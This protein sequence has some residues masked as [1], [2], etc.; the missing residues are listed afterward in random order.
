MCHGNPP[1]QVPACL[2]RWL[3]CRT[4]GAGQRT[5]SRMGKNVKSKDAGFIRFL[6]PSIKF[7]YK[8]KAGG[9]DCDSR[10]R[11]VIWCTR[12]P[13]RSFISLR[14]RRFPA[15]LILP[16]RTLPP[17]RQVATGAAIELLRNAVV[18]SWAHTPIVLFS[19]HRLALFFTLC[20]STKQA[21]G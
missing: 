2:A 9:R 18:T 13:R 8:A 19:F 7:F 17:V 20:N 11:K 1:F 4:R 12:S 5:Y 10:T 16:G 21:T 3:G 6:S 14:L 15:C